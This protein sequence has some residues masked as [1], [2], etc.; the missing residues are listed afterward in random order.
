MP[1]VLLHP[2]IKG[3]KPQQWPK[4]KNNKQERNKEPKEQKNDLARDFRFSPSFWQQVL[5]TRRERERSHESIPSR[6]RIGWRI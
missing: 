6:R 2:L 5:K 1:T 3:Y 4:N